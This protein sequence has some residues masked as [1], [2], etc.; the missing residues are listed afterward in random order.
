MR[1]VFLIACI[2][3]LAACQPR[4]LASTSPPSGLT[5]AWVTFDARGVRGS[6]ASGLAD[7]T[8]GRAVAVDDPV[9]IASIS[10]LVVALG[11][12]RLVEQGKVDIEADVSRQ[13][14]WMLRNPAH[15]D[16]PITL[17]MLLSH[18]SSIKD[19]GDNYVLP[20][21]RTVRQTT[22]LPETFDRANR[23]GTF[24][25]YSNLNYPIIASVLE[26]ATA[27]RFD[28]LMDRLVLQPLGLDACFNYTT[29]SDAKLARIVVLYRPDGSVA[30]DDLRGRRPDCAVATAGPACDLETY[31]L[32]SN[33]ALFSPQGGLRA[34]MTD[35]ATIGQM[36]LNRGR[37]RG[38]AFLSPAGIDMILRPVWVFNGR[39]GDTSSGLYCAYGLA[40]QSLPITFPG[41]RDN[42]LANG[43]KLLGHAGE[44]YNLRSGL[45]IDP[46][47]A[48][49][50][51]YFA[52]NTAEE[53]SASAYSPTEQQLA[54][55]LPAR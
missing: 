15:P 29:C 47:A 35:L 45:W 53:V 25:R 22:A 19:E 28:K 49:G 26:K 51:A 50:I 55:K 30:R 3:I 34:S 7:R 23:P 24:F 5:T 21:G 11:V 8:S 14:G 18:T 38:G 54:S 32:G 31:Q 6:G 39:N 1:P 46:Q 13:L 20:L 12:M 44:A 4:P 41:C 43:R 48:V 9:R 37:H 17:R 40:S 33:G 52:A 36:L 42:L 27:E 10:K 16:V 2:L